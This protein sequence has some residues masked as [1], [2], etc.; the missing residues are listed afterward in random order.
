MRYIYLIYVEE[1]PLVE[2]TNDHPDTGSALN[3]TFATE[4]RLAGVYVSASTLQPTLTATT[5]RLSAGKPDVNDGPAVKM[6]LPL[7]GFVVL[8]VADERD[9]LRWA[10]RIPA[11]ADGAVEVR[12]IT[13]D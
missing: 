2:G 7:S 9:A 3:R 8:D 13:Y 5:L 11:A 12:Q 4:A 10:A 1:R 6:P